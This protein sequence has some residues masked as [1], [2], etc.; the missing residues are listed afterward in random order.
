MGYGSQR[1]K[2]PLNSPTEEIL[3]IDRL[4]E[5]RKVLLK[6]SKVVLRNGDRTMEAYAILDDG[7]ERTILLHSAAQ[8]LGLKGEPEDLPLR[9]VRQELQMLHGAMVSFTISPAAEPHRVF[10]VQQAFTAKPLG[11]AVHSHPV[12]A[13]QKKYWH[14]RDLPLQPLHLVHPVLL[15]GSDHPHLITPVEPVRLGPPRGPAAVKTR[16]GWCLQGPAQGLRHQLSEQQCLFTS[17]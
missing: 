1:I 8:Q 12:E 14:L 9:T 17:L 16:L 6:V 13:L 10:S 3:Y 11:L 15:I 5:G 4:L 7:S 2:V